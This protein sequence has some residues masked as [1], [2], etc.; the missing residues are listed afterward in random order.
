MTT[1]A[2]IEVPIP[3]E[4]KELAKEMGVKEE[5]L[6]KAA[7]RLLILE[8]ATLESKLS[9]EEALKLAEEVERSA[10]RSSQ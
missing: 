4:L 2:T 7:Q 10:W 9:K 5:K 6:I 1:T 3:R 8:I